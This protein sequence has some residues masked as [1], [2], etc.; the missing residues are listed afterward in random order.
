MSKSCWSNI[1]YRSFRSNKIYILDVVRKTEHTSF[2]ITHID[3]FVVVLI[4]ES[5]L[6]KMGI[7]Q[8]TITNINSLY[9]AFYSMD[10]YGHRK[11]ILYGY[12]HIVPLY[13]DTQRKQ[14]RQDYVCIVQYQFTFF[15]HRIEESHV[16]VAQ[17][18]GEVSFGGVPGPDRPDRARIL[19]EP[20]VYFGI[21]RAE[22]QSLLVTKEEVSESQTPPLRGEV[23]EEEPVSTDLY[24]LKF[25]WRS[26]QDR[27]WKC[28]FQKCSICTNF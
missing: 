13:F 9:I 17:E 10:I 28:V 6:L 19:D 21:L 22:K 2:E 25:I 15:Q 24:A 11:Y 18:P 23:P 27:T 1:F 20:E 12:V 7:E 5:R 26:S 16:D 3:Q 14:S 4:D 8:W